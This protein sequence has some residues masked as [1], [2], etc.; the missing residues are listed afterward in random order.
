MKISIVFDDIPED[1]EMYKA[2][3]SHK[4]TIEYP[5]VNIDTVALN[6][7]VSEIRNEHGLTVSKECKLDMSFDYYRGVNDNERIK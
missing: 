5:D 1:S 6:N 4:V 3:N 7:V 2:Y